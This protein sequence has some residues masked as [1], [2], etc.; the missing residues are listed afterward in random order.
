MPLPDFVIVGTC[1]SGSTSLHQNLRKHPDIFT[2]SNE[3]HY[4]YSQVLGKYENGL[5]W[6]QQHFDEAD[7]GQMVGEKTPLYSYVPEAAPRMHEVLPDAKLIWIF[8][9]PVQRAHSHY[10]YIA[11]RGDEPLSFEEAIRKERT[12]QREDDI[13]RAYLRSGLYAEQVERYLEWFDRDAMFFCTF[14]AFTSTPK[15]VLRRLYAF[16]EV[17]P[18]YAEQID[19]E[20]RKTTTHTP[21]FPWLRH[22]VLKRFGGQSLA[23][24]IEYKV[25]SRSQSG[26]PEMDPGMRQSLHV[27]Y[28]SS[29]QRLRE[30][31]NLDLR[32]WYQ[33]ENS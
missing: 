33:P 29:N 24:K 6:Y 12:G 1:K 9:E 11:S 25:N 7:D 21:Y 30:L 17:D 10:W 23:R 28:T 5:D 22:V 14:R 4:F 13:E 27:Y 8:R 20:R 32:H 31:T 15:D 2:P 19:V 26:Y 18:E 3:V 16:L